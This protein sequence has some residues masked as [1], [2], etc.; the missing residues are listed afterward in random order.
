MFAFVTWLVLI[1]S[2]LLYNVHE[3]LVLGDQCV[4]YFTE[5]TFQLGSVYTKRR[6]QWSRF[7]MRLQPILEQLHC[8]E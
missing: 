1:L 8:F 4:R 6:R 5:G 7:G 2:S 3:H